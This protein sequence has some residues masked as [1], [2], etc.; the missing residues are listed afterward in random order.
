MYVYKE[1]NS[2]GHAPSGPQFIL[3]ILDFY[4]LVDFHTSPTDL[5]SFF[6]LMMVMMVMMMAMMVMMAMMMMLDRRIF[7]VLSKNP[8]LF[9]FFFYQ[10]GFAF[11]LRTT[12]T[13]RSVNTPLQLRSGE[14]ADGMI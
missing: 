4:T 12:A 13:H 7:L 1:G 6:L 9:S 8:L 11:Q 14:K 10:H 5:Q 2:R 3:E